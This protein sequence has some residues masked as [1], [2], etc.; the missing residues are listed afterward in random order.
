MVGECRDHEFHD[1]R[2]RRKNSAFACALRRHCSARAV[3]Y[4]LSTVQLVLQ[5]QARRSF[6]GCVATGV[7]AGWRVEVLPLLLLFPSCAH[8]RELA[9]AA[10]SIGVRLALS[11]SPLARLSYA[12]SLSLCARALCVRFVVCSSSL[13]LSAP[14]LLK[15]LAAFDPRRARVHVE[16]TDLAH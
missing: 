6:D 15:T 12:Q 5:Q 1:R 4:A 11:V 14:L 10:H 16:S 9:S 8:V 3:A 7:C 13:A 2:I